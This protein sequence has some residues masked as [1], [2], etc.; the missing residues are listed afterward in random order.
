MVNTD[1]PGDKSEYYL[2][3]TLIHEGKTYYQFKPEGTDLDVHLNIG[4]REDN[5]V[6]Y[7]YHGASSQMGVNTSAGVITSLNTK[8]AVGEVWT[9]QVTLNISGAASGTLKHTNEGK[10]LAKTTSVAVNGK[11]YKDVIKT[12]TKKTVRNSIT[13]YSLTII[14]EAW[15]AKGVGLIYEK[16]TYD[17]EVVEQHQLTSYSLN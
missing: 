17:N 2:H 16:N 5:G 11:T 6:F 13:G 1:D 14:Y 7:E 9:D 10:I 8:L 3:K 12:E 15:L 4:I